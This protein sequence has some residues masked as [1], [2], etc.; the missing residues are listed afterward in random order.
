MLACCYLYTGFTAPG[1][2]SEYKLQKNFRFVIR[3]SSRCLI[4]KVQCSLLFR[5]AFILYH[6]AGSLSRT[7]FISF[8]QLGLMRCADLSAATFIVYH[9][10]LRLS[11]TFF[12][13]FQISVCHDHRF[14]SGNS[15]SLTCFDL[16]V[17][18][19]FA[20]RPVI[21]TNLFGFLMPSR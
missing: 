18:H 21:S 4:Y 12:D 1:S 7:F 5:V 15:I 10:F 19:F 20:S 14:F 6:L 9:D 17:K 13:L 8:S 2:L 16:I 11:R 3:S